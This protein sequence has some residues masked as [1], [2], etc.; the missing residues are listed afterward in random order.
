[1]KPYID[2]ASGRAIAGALD[3]EQFVHLLFQN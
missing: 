3:F 1:M 2:A